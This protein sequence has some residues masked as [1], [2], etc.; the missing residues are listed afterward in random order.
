MNEATKQKFYVGNDAQWKNIYECNEEGRFYQES[1][2][3]FVVCNYTPSRSVS[4]ECEFI[5]TWPEKF[6]KL[7]LQYILNTEFAN[8]HSSQVTEDGYDWCNT[9]DGCHRLNL[10]P[11]FIKALTK[12]ENCLGIMYDELEHS[13]INRNLTLTINRTGKHLPVFPL[14][15]AKDVVIQGELLRLQLKELAD[16]HKNNGA[17]RFVGEHVFPVLFHS[18]AAS[19]IIP[20]FKSQKE[21][22]SV[23][24]YVNAA[25]AALQYGTELWN[26]VDLWNYNTF[27]GHS[28]KEMYYNLWFSYLVGTNRVYVE[29]ASQFFKNGKKTEYAEE[30]K[31][32]C[33]DD[34][35]KYRDY[36]V[37]DYKPEIGIIRYDD[38]YWGQCDPF[39][40]R[41]ILLGNKSLK[42]T[43]TAKEFTR[44]FHIVTHGE[45]C[46][47]GLAWDR[48]S[49]WSLRPHKS[50]CSMNGV[51]VFDDRVTKEKLETLK[52]CFLCGHY[53]S[54]KTIGDIIKLVKYNGLTV[55]TPKRF[56]PEYIKRQTKGAFSEI[57]DG[58]GKWIVTN[59]VLSAKTKKSVR[60]FIGIKGEMKFT[61][62]DKTIR[63]KISKDG[64]SFEII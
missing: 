18:F 50:F 1:E 34:R 40:W 3:D 11:D 44:V 35:R 20:N 64:N 54:D 8:W 2:T 38:S 32:F 31:K 60:H 62:G 61:F 45:T 9:D 59:N 30:Y 55:V 23:V 21:S 16:F 19:G 29:G 12:D 4:G 43:K 42:V 41:P 7:N 51:A 6:S 36:S 57:K 52:L 17:K 27:P 10:H 33:T 15:L 26:C 53:I 47:N 46:K 22:Y 28:P 48:I 14:A 25:G 56:C 5:S 37:Q 58:K 39:M 63:M 49:P 13:I 24:Q